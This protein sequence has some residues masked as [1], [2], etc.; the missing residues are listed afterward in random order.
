VSAYITRIARN[1]C[2]SAL[3]LAA[4][5]RGE[6]QMSEVLEMTQVHEENL[7]E[8]E[9]LLEKSE[10]LAVLRECVSKLKESEQRLF[11]Q[12]SSITDRRWQE[13]AS[14]L[15]ESE[16]TLRSQ[17]KKIIDALRRCFRLRT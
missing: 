4:R 13:A 1:K 12:I 6:H 9:D 16:S 8:H 10:Q 14:T 17:W 3:R 7:S 15:G 11:S 5:E 2:A